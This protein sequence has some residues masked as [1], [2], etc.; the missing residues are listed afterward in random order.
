MP[1]RHKDCDVEI[2]DPGFEARTFPTFP[3]EVHTF[4]QANR[5]NTIAFL[6]EQERKREERTRKRTG[7]TEQTGR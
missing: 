2:E 1:T 5:A 6:A 3:P 7:K 4:L